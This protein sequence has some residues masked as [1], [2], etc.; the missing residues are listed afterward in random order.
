MK[1]EKRES[2]M[3]AAMVAVALLSA[4]AVRGLMAPSGISAEAQKQP[5]IKLQPT[6]GAPGSNVTITGSDF[7]KDSM[8]KLTLEGKDLNVGNVKTGQD[9]SFHTS[10]M[11]PM[12]AK[13]GKNQIKTSDDKGKSATADVT[14]KKSA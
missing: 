5:S 3:L 4:I 11:V 2:A 8:V 1:V 6:T 7:S 14:V 9:G 13:E 10:A 12:D